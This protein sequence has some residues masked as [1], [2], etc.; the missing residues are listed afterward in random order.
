MYCERRLKWFGYLKRVRS[1]RIPNMIL[2]RN[3]DGRGKRGS[4]RENGDGEKRSKINKYITEKEVENDGW[5]EKKHDQQ[6]PHR[7]C[8]T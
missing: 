4:L 1:N 3:F 2:E 6:R 8:R 7:R 5:S